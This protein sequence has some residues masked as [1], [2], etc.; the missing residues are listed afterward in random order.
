MQPDIQLH[1]V[2]TRCAVRAILSYSHMELQLLLFTAKHTVTPNY[3]RMHSRNHP[4]LQLQLVQ[5]TVIPSY[6]LRHRY[7]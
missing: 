5:D 2:T 1:P 6:S 3:I 4:Q 7:S